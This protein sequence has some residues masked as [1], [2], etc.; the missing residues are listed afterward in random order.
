VIPD[1]QVEEVRA[2]ADIVDVISQYV[3]LKK[4]GKEFKANCPFHEERTPSFYVVPDKGFYKCFG[5]GVSGDVFKFLQ[6][7]VGLDFVE[8]VKQVASRS[9]V[10]IREVK[11]G[12]D[13]EEDPKRPLYELMAFAR[14]WFREQLLGDGGAGARA[15]LEGRGI[16]AET[17]ERFDLGFAP[18][19]WRALRDAAHGL[20][21]TDA[22]LLEVGLLT[23]SE[24][25][26]EPYDK[27]RNRV[28]FPIEALRGK[29]LA[30]G[31]R[32]LGEEKRG[33]PKY[34]NSPE[35]VLYH[36]GATLYGLDKS[37]H[38]I[39]REEVALV[40][41][42]YMD[43]VSIAAFG[44]E[45]TVATLGT[46]MTIEQARLLK[47]YTSRVLLLFDSDRAGLKASFRA[48]DLLLSEGLHPS[49]VT[50]PE[51]E[52]PDT[53]VQKEGAD[54]LRGYLDDA[55]DILDRKLQILEKRD[56]FAS[57][58][59]RRDAVDRLLPTLRA[60]KDQTLRDIY[61]DQVAGR[62][63]VR[64]ETLE[65][66]LARNP[67]T[68][69]QTPDR[70]AR[71]ADPA[72]RRARSVDRRP[73]L[74]PEWSLLRV[75][76]RDRDRRHEL[77]EKALMRIGPEDFKDAVDRA[78]FQS[79]V[80]DPD[81]DRPPEDLD[82]RAVPRLEALLAE[83]VDEEQLAHGGRE[84]DEALMTLEG[85]RIARRIDA[86]QGRIEAT[87]DEDEKLELIR[88]KQTLGAELRALGRPGGSYARRYTR[89][90]HHHDA[91]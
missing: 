51:G 39:R 5:C 27:F 15:Y 90:S 66:E 40:V 32:L 3:D 62:T 19:D 65:Q 86:L 78:I 21:M 81:L 8:A 1:D 52:D 28:I 33:Q 45:N 6:E 43:L 25:S 34:L 68:R 73:Q 22:Q 31:G 30:F 67:G 49:I 36:K 55:V 16:D 13:P 14:T 64:R 61:I 58:D 48:G 24:K 71:R 17:S 70:G 42:G 83:P 80:D 87:T 44:F 63:G 37:R 4:A 11:R 20:G 26:P 29:V 72:P 69:S 53:L 12:H 7:K 2:R 10:E 85:M 74:G 57:I 88:E 9:G 82:A 75:L 84:F 38:A 91:Q 18:D 50:L 89:G 54:A 60:T 47:R 77:V 59:G 23:T 76:A 46:A 56:Y 41:E 35:T 79:F